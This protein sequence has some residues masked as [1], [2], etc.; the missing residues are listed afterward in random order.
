MTAKTDDKIAKLMELAHEQGWTVEQ[1]RNGKLKWMPPDKTVNAVFTATGTSGRSYANAEAELRRAGLDTSS[2]TDRRTEEESNFEENETIGLYRQA[3]RLNDT[4]LKNLIVDA[5][6]R[7][8]EKCLHDSLNTADQYV[9]S[10]TYAA[11]MLTVALLAGVP[12]RREGEGEQWLAEATR[13][14]AAEEHAAKLAEK[15]HD[16][17]T[18]L[19][20]A[21][22]EVVLATERA[23]KAENKL[24]TFRELMKED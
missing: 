14:D 6:E 2:I 21:Q 7:V 9:D 8:G 4:L 3:E 12:A 5:T 19:V 10:I 1:N 16:L 24:R 23:L 22:N 13:A 20:E 11:R 18:S 15:V 17:G